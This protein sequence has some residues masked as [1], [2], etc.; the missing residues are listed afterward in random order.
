MVVGGFDMWGWDCNGGGDHGWD[1][2]VLTWVSSILVGNCD[3][4]ILSLLSFLLLLLKDLST[5]V[6]YRL[7]QSQYLKDL[8]TPTLLEFEDLDRRWSDW[9]FSQFL[10]KILYITYLFL[11]AFK[12][13]KNIIK[14]KKERY[15]RYK[16]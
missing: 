15:F 11:W 1:L 13:T 2:M 16:K 7:I 9:T 6:E 5:R 10:N 4:E 14:K 8:T 3:K 12:F